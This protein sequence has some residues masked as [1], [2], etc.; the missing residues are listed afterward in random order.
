[1][2]YAETQEWVRFGRGG[3]HKK[4]QLIPFVDRFW[5]YVLSGTGDEC[6]QWLGA[7][8]KN[9]GYGKAS[10][11]NR[12]RNV[13]AH[14]VAWM[15]ANKQD[16]PDGMLV[17]HTCDNRA[18]V[19]PKH[20]FLGTRLDNQRDMVAKGRSAKGEKQHSAKLTEEQVRDIR[21]RNPSQCSKMDLA[22]EFGV[23]HSS[24]RSVLAR[25]TWRHVG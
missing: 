15:L 17:C 16:V 18:C 1:M 25:R 19:N 21:N 2:N 9:T 8:D 13:G 4:P 23:R 10:E 24:I 14:R 11:A 5:S 6:W 22:R 3:S 7:I 12:V 20:L